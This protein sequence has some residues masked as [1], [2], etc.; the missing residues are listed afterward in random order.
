M[1]GDYVYS[2]F[3]QDEISDQRFRGAKQLVE[4]IICKRAIGPWV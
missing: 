3:G 2:H 4:A 1:Y